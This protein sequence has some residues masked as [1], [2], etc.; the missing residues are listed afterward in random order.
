[1]LAGHAHGPPDLLSLASSECRIAVSV[2]RQFDPIALH[3]AP[4]LPPLRLQKTG[5]AAT[6]PSSRGLQ[7]SPTTLARLPMRSNAFRSFA[8]RRPLRLPWFL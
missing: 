2:R 4:R 8:P 1:M 5:S 6:K 7:K 3:P